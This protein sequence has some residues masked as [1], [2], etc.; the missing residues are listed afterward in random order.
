MERLKVHDRGWLRAWAWAMAT[1]SYGTGAKKRASWGGRRG[2]RRGAGGIWDDE[3]SC[4]ILHLAGSRR[5]ARLPAA[6]NQMAGITLNR[7][8]FEVE[9]RGGARARGA[10][11]RHRPAAYHVHKDRRSP[12]LEPNNQD[13]QAAAGR[14]LTSQTSRAYCDE[15]KTWWLQLQRWRDTEDHVS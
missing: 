2:G 4:A 7:G 9:G 3:S 5:A 13:W 6:G 15:S 14:L 8:I 12:R 11:K 1:L 10:Q